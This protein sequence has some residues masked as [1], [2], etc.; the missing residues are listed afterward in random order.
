MTGRWFLLG[1]ILSILSSFVLLC[2]GYVSCLNFL[3]SINLRYLHWRL[4]WLDSCYYLRSEV[5]C[6]LPER[7][8]AACF[9]SYIVYIMVWSHSEPA[10]SSTKASIIRTILLFIF[11]RFMLIAGDIDNTMNARLL[12]CILTMEYN[13]YCGD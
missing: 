13:K 2:G 4:S 11:D 6:L 12:I 7:C 9:V 8:M 5:H 3:L 10:A 1:N